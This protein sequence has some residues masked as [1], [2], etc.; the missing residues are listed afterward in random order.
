[1]TSVFLVLDYRSL[2]VVSVTVQWMSW[3]F[4]S[5]GV[6]VL[7]ITA[8]ISSCWALT[9]FTQVQLDNNFLH[10]L[11]CVSHLLPQG[12]CTDVEIWKHKTSSWSK[13]RTSQKFRG[14]ILYGADS[15]DQLTRV[16]DGSF[17]SLS[18]SVPMICRGWLFKVKH[19]DTLSSQL[20]STSWDW[21]T[22]LLCSIPLESYF[23]SLGFHFLIDVYTCVLDQSLIFGIKTNKQ[24][25]LRQY[26]SLM[27]F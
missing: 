18:S 23:C 14:L 5:L 24:T 4:L 27:I 17:F 1:M 25:K 19:A 20:D 15:F 26:I 11:Q 3:T 22:C 21:P 7:S 16:V 8:H 10:A 6:S 12:I 2:V 13:A 9:K